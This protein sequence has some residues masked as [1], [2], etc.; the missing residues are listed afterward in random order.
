MSRNETQLPFFQT[1]ALQTTNIDTFISEIEIL[2][3]T[4][5]NYQTLIESAKRE[6]YLMERD[7]HAQLLSRTGFVIQDIKDLEYEVRNEIFSV[8][9][10]ECLVVARSRLETASN[11][12]GESSLLA[13]EHA[14][15]GVLDLPIFSV[16]PVLNALTHIIPP[17]ILDP[18]N[19]LGFFNP[20]TEFDRSVETLI[21]ETENHEMLFEGFVDQIL[22]EM[23]SL[24]FYHNDLH[25]TFAF[26]MQDTQQTFVNATSDIRNY[27]STE[28]N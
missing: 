18:L 10:P 19:I 16:Y 23:R 22:S 13:H 9:N 14:M 4:N 28:C 15:R 20:I 1:S 27:L 25:R 5:T 11:A 24:N 3:R 6:L 26:E 8:D 17:F 21:R 2:K 12:A 7:F